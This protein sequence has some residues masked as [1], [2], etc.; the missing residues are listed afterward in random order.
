MTILQ[1]PP[2]DPVRYLA[3]S[4]C[5]QQSQ[6]L[7][8]LQNIAL[9]VGPQLTPKCAKLLS[10]GYPELV[11]LWSNLGRMLVGNRWNLPNF[12]KCVFR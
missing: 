7:E 2:L 10:Q 9:W 8:M 5:K 11:S 12:V 6:A 3:E 4:K 1:N